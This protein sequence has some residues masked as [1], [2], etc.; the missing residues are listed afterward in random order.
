MRRQKCLMPSLPQSLVG[1][2]LVLRTT[3][4]LGWQNGPPGIQEAVRELLSCLDV[5]KSMGSD[6][7][8][9]RVMREMADE[10]A[11]PLSIIYQQ[12]WLN[13]EVPDDRK[14]ANVMPIHKKGGK[15]DPGVAIFC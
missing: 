2:H 15:K 3:V 1:R 7:I 6:G 8:H 11:K 5:H 13:G 9:P 10:L 4:L 12:S 14:L